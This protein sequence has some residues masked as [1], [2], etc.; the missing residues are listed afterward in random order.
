MMMEGRVMQKKCSCGGTCAKCQEERRLQMRQKSPGEEHDTWGVESIVK[1]S[2]K[3]LDPSLRS[4]MEGRLGH[5]L[6]D[7]RIHDDAAAHSSADRVGA[8]AYTVGNHVAF[9]P[10]RFRPSTSAG[11]DLI[12]HELVHTIQQRNLPTS[13]PIQ[14]DSSST[15]AESEATQIGRQS[16]KPRAP[17]AAVGSSDR[18]AQRESPTMPEVPATAFMVGLNLDTDGKV[19]ATLSGPGIKPIGPPS[20]GIRRTPDGDYK[21]FVG[22]RG[23]TVAASDIPDMFKKAL[24]APNPRVPFKQTTYYPSCESAVSE[25]QKHYMNHREYSSLAN[26]IGSLALSPFFYKAFIEKCPKLE[27]PAPEPKQEAKP[28]PQGGDE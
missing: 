27:P 8:E 1:G 28:G 19:E 6:G 22:A 24:V 16:G 11:R 25:D 7:V 3:S 15:P 9:G 26:S 12:A 14:V 23:K 2:G 10:G 17:I 20:I 21:V 4:Q 13:G 5:K 18:I